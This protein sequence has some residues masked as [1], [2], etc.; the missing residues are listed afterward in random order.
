MAAFIQ[1][2]R[3]GSIVEVVDLV[4]LSGEGR[5]DRR[6]RQL[7]E[8]M[9]GIEER[10]G[11]IRELSTGDE[12]PKQ[13]KRMLMRAYTM[14]GNIHRRANGTKGGRPATPMTEHEK[15]VQ[16]G[17]WHSRRYKNNDERVTAIKKRLGWSF[18]PTELRKR[19]G[20]PGGQEAANT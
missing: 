9:E 19:Y 2:I 4:W 15:V 3:P 17:I 7:V 18:G 10:G 20:P 1:S 13:T 11:R 14:I 8:N 16:E 5:S 12:T 6:R